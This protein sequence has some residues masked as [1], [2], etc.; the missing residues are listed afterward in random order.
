MRTIQ[1]KEYMSNVVHV[2]VVKLTL[3]VIFTVYTCDNVLMLKAE[4][5]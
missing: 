2:W 5:L 3:Y 4:N 1:M